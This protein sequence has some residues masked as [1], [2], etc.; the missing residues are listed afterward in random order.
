MKGLILAG[1]TGSRIKPFSL[2]TAKQLLPILNKPV[3]FHNIDLLLAGGIYDIGLVVGPM[4]DHVIKA[5]TNSIYNK[6]ANIHFIDQP[7][8]KGLAHAV[9]TSQSFLKDD[10]FVMILGDN[11]FTIH[12]NDL[13]NTFYKQS[14]DTLVA[15]TQ[16][17]EPERYGIAVMENN[18][19]VSVMEKPKLSP[20]NWALAGLYIF[21]ST[22]HKIIENL[23]PSYRNEYEITDAIQELIK[24]RKTVIP[25]FLKGYWRDIGTIKDLFETNI[26]LLQN[27]N[28]ENSQFSYLEKNFTKIHSPVLIDKTAV[29][30]DSVIGP[31]VIIGPGTNVINSKISNSIVLENAIVNQV[32]KE[33]MIFSSWGNKEVKLND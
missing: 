4:K 22:I 14:A 12:T 10:D 25:Y 8:P 6:L 13:L 31:N 7:D 9:F 1:G 17:K 27:T 21:K 23:Q 11:F 19:I 26:D 5:I 3:L 15:L 18:E 28:P 32:S 30:L 33:N 29:I 20:S 16:V 2:H 24:K